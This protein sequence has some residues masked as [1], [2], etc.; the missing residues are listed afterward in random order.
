MPKAVE[1]VVKKCAH[2][3]CKKEFLDEW[4]TKKFCN[5]ECKKRQ[6]W[7]ERQKKGDK[8]GGYN[9]KVYISLWCKAA[10]KDPGTVPCHYCET[11][12]TVDTFVIDHKVPSSELKTR[13]EKQEMDN[14]V[15]S[16]KSCNLQKGVLPYEMF[17]TWKQSTIIRQEPDTENTASEQDDAFAPSNESILDKAS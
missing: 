17:Y 6:R 1:K 5:E 9:R 2:V 11:E 4:G 10:G 13:E 8:R 16:C 15:I 14:L 3:K 7:L 12:L